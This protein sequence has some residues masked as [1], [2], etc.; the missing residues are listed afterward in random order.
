MIINLKQPGLLQHT[1]RIKT[2]LFQQAQS[3]RTTNSTEERR[4]PVIKD[5]E[6][7]NKETSNIENASK[8]DDEKQV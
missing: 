3:A 4:I 7:K 2:A 5:D 8:G 1:L 6:S